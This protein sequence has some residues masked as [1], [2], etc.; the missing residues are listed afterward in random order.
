M[1]EWNGMVILSYGLPFSVLSSF[2]INILWSTFGPPHNEPWTF[3][4]YIFCNFDLHVAW[5][6]TPVLELTTLR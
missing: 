5:P 6:S 3:I 2:S 4:E 1:E